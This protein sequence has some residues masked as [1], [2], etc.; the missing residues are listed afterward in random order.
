MLRNQIGSFQ[1]ISKKTLTNT[2]MFEY[3]KFSNTNIAKF[4]KYQSP[5]RGW[6]RRVRLNQLLFMKSIK[7]EKEGGVCYVRLF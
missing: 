6:E 4:M 2:W 3:L 5:E 7:I 1:N